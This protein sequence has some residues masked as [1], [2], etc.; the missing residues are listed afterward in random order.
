[1][2]GFTSLPLSPAL[3][4]SIEK[5][6]FREPS[7]VQRL[8]IPAL[9]GG[10]SA[11]VVARTGS[12]KTLAY[13]V[14]VLQRLRAIEDAEGPVTR[15]GAPRAVVLTSTRELV[16]QA[17][18]DIKVLAHGPRLRVRGVSGGMN[19]RQVG[20]RLADPCDVLVANPPRLRALVEAGTVRLDDVRVVVVDEGDTLCSPGQ[21][22]DVERVLAA[23]PPG[24][25]VLVSA[26]LPEAIRSWALARP[27]RPTL[28]LARDAHATPER[29]K[30]RNLTVKPAH[31][32]DAA[33]EVLVEQPEGTRGIVFANRR[34]SAEAAAAAL[35]E[36]GSEVICVHGGQLPKERKARIDAFRAGQG[37]VLVTTELAGRGL[38]VPG[39]AFV[40]NYELPERVS[41]Y[42]HRVGRVGRQGARGEVINLVT[43]R[44]RELLAAIERLARGGRMDTGEPVRQPRERAPRPP[45]PERRGRRR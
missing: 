3:L 11:L 34:E 10:A 2:T 22:G 7:P 35:T 20:E 36:R 25:L 26:T 4:A 24:Q 28:L 12:G 32:A 17:T 30:V 14:P 18:R 41:D 6:A 40:L 31:R 44:D 21:R 1:M 43:D 16:D 13:A 9:A 27:E 45:K 33:H 19:A 39:L 37:R 23:R 29:V 15:R 42:L 38:H 8:A 5:L